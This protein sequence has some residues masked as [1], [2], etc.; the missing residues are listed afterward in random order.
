MLSFKDFTVVDYTQTGDPQ[1]I[2]NAKKRHRG[3]V[4]EET[5]DEALDFAA[6]RAKARVMKR[7][8]AKLA[9]GRRRASKKAAGKDR[10]LK[11]ARKQ[12]HTQLFK[13]FSKGKSRSALPASRRAE[14]EKRIAGMKGRVNVIAKKALPQVRKM[15]KQRR[16][17]AQ[18][19]AKK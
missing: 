7:I 6:R 18:G 15:E 9:M 14:I 1:Q 16:M 13:K 19:G 4:G 10:L 5:T 8:K 17:A 12:A 3:V 11:R 2:Q